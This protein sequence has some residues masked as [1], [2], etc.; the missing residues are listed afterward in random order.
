MEREIEISLEKLW[1][2]IEIG[3]ENVQSFGQIRPANNTTFRLKNAVLCAS[4]DNR[5]LTEP[6]LSRFIGM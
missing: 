5:T 6:D 4:F 1:E 3:F 2:I